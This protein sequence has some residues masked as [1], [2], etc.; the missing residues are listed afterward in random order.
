MHGR[1]MESAINYAKLLAV[2]IGL[3][4]WNTPLLAQFDVQLSQYMLVPGVFNPAVA[5]IS[6]DLHATIQNRQQWVGIENGGN[7]FLANVSAPLSSSNQKFGIGVLLEKDDIGLFST[8]IFQLQLAW[9]RPLLNGIISLGLQGGI[10]QQGFDASGIYIPNLGDDYHVVSET[11]MPTGTLEGIAPDFSSGIWFHTSG[12]YAGLSVSH[13]LE[14]SVRLKVSDAESQDS[15]PMFIP[16]R[17]YYFTHG[18]N[19]VLTNPFYTLQPSFLLKTDLTAWQT[20]LSCR[21]LYKEKISG[22]ISWRFKD[23]VILM[24]G[25]KL[26]HGLSIGYSYDVSTSA[27]ASFSSGSHELFIGYTK[28]LSTT[29]V[30]K[31]QKSVRIL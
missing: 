21:V 3:S 25:I 13:L 18:Y 26:Q 2:L 16:S 24:A 6:G 20:D 28:K 5:G 29:S 19:I 1:N 11:N 8:Q 17:S 10:L 31:K 15:D 30:S 14:S 4:C 12:C 27:V 22:G 23:A 7:T 9:R